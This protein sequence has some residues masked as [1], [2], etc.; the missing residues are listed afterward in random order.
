MCLL[1]IF[2]FA[3]FLIIALLIIFKVMRLHKRGI[4]VRAGYKKKHLTVFFLYPVFFL[5]LFLWLMAM[6]IQ[7]FQ[8]PVSTDFVFLIRKQVDSFWFS[9]TGAGL[10]ILSIVVMFITLLHFRSSLRFGMNKKNQGNLITTGIFSYSRNPFF[11]SLDLYFIGQAMVF[12]GYLFVV[13]ALLAVTGIHFFIMKEEKF[14][15]AYYREEYLEY[16]TKVRRYF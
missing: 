2:P 13:M 3:G 10:I 16:K 15:W 1:G 11:L 14:L 5:L 4:S 12:P 8:I 9:A 6:A 7:T